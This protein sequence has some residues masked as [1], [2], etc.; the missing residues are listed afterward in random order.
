MLTSAVL[1][2]IE[3]AKLRNRSEEDIKVSRTQGKSRGLNAT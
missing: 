2:G 1:K 3:E